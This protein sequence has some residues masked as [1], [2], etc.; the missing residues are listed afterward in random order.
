MLDEFG[1]CGSLHD[2]SRQPHRDTHSRFALDLCPCVAPKT[3]SYLI[4]ANLHADFLQD[5][6]RMALDF[7]QLFFLEHLVGWNGALD[8]RDRGWIHG[9]NP[10]AAVFPWARTH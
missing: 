6:I 5:S 8:E 10:L 1:W 9:P 4:A 7:H 3:N 2:L